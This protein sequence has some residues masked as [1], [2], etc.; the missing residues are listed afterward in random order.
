MDSCSRALSFDWAANLQFTKD[1]IVL[2][3]CRPQRGG[4]FSA[5]GKRGMDGK[6]ME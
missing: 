6:K 5:Q 4:R 1:I 2:K 3:Y